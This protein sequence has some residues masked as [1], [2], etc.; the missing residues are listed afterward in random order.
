MVLAMPRFSAMVFR[1]RSDQGP[2]FSLITLALTLA[3]F[4]VATSWASVTGGFNGV[5]NIPGL[6]G[7]DGFLDLYYLIAVVLGL[8]IASVDYLLRAPIGAL[9]RAAADN[10]RRLAFLGYDV[11]ALKAVAFAVACGL[12]GL[13]GALYAP[14]QN[15]VTPDLAGFTFSGIVIFAAVG[16]RAT[17]LGPVLGAIVVGVLSAE[18]RDRFPWWQI[19]IALFFIFVTSQSQWIVYLPVLLASIVVMVPAIIAAE[20]FRR[21]KAVLIGAVAA[22]AISQIMLLLSGHHVYLVLAAITIFFAGFNITEASLP[23]LITKTAPPDAKGTAAGVYSS[24]QFL[25]IF[26]GGAAGGWIHQNAGNAGVFLLSAGLA[27][28]WLAAAATMARPSY[29]TTRLVR[30]SDS[31][32]ANAE[33]LAA[34]LRQMP[35]VADA[36]VIA[37]E[38][39][40]YL[41]VDFKLLRCGAHG[42]TYQRS[43]AHHLPARSSA[44]QMRKLGKFSNPQTSGQLDKSAGGNVSRDE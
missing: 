10:E 19:V 20:K 2:S 41:K 37:E 4:Q 23:S 16:G 38:K 40:A 22:L 1:G 18:L 30:L 14:Q 21:M 31:Q 12:A 42:S 34:K 36:V 24:S 15:L 6:P 43:L 29:L 28:L 32:V 17:V 13:A 7:L 5:R 3:A 9:W 11:A 25:G 8:G 35:G 39:L 33:S 27:L 26:V 44:P